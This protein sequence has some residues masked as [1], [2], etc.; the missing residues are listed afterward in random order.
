M[1]VSRDWSWSN[2]NLFDV[3]ML[4]TFGGGGEEAH[5]DF[6]MFFS[7]GRVIVEWVPRHPRS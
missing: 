3:S 6:A 5:C 4:V 1:R 7:H 2:I